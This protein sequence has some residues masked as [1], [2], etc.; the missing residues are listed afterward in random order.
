[1]PEILEL[2]DD[3]PVAE[4]AER[5]AISPL[6]VRQQIHGGGLRG[7]RRAGRWF[8]PVAELD[9]VSKL[10]RMPGRPYDQAPAWALIALASD[11]EHESG[12]SPARVSQLR[13]ALLDVD[14]IDGLLYQLRHRADRQLGY[15]HP[16]LLDDL[17]ADDR[18]VPGGPS[19]LPRESIDLVDGQ[20]PEEVY[21][22]RG[23]WASVADEYAIQDADD[24]A[25]LVV[26]V[27]EAGPFLQDGQL[28]DLAVA[29]DLFESGDP[30]AQYA[31]RV[32][33]RA[34]LAH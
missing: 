32:A 5:L 30:R 21:I 31:A 20:L 24:L 2:H 14:D 25:N 18:I 16:S 22:S 11:N 8:V 29:L 6:A 4:A 19:A 17:L 1:M 33:W 15:V 13:R 34:A 27:V 7:R 3:V 23:D 12:L 26:H 28:P 9:R 10:P